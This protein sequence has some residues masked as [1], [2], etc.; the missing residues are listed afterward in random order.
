MKKKIVGA[1]VVGALFA[2]SGCASGIVT[3]KRAPGVPGEKTF[4]VQIE[5]GRVVGP[6][7]VWVT[8][9]EEVWEVCGLEETYPSCAG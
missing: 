2:V 4:Q 5:E 3:D 6:D 9:P 1:V 7:E 8:V